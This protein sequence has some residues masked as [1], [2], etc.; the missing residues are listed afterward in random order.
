MK[1]TLENQYDVSKKVVL[2]K[3]LYNC[4]LMYD[5]LSATGKKMPEWVIAGLSEIN[6]KTVNIL[7]DY[8]SGKGKARQPETIDFEVQVKIAEAIA[9]DKDKLT[10]LFNKLT[11]LSA[12]ASPCSLE[13]TIPTHK[14]FFRA[15]PRFVRLI[16]DFWLISLSCLLGYLLLSVF[17]TKRVDPGN[18]LDSLILFQLQLTFSAGLGACFY[19]L[20]TARKYIV[21][22]TFD[23]NYITHYYNR[24]IIGIIAGII[25]ANIINESFFKGNETGIIKQLTP[26][27][28]AL[29]GGYSAEAVVKIL[30]RLVDMLTTLVE[31]D[32]RNMVE[33]RE[34]EIKN[35]FEA[36][37]IKLNIATIID[38]HNLLQTSKLDD[39]TKEKVQDIIDNLLKAD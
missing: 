23:N 17:M 3:L 37:K 27:V 13:N 1:N 20:N 4:E 7:K 14:L 35:K 5:Y 18:G 26:S 32:A 2:Y 8:E 11:D 34:M 9:G 39:K 6:I 33:T 10:L 24:I 28:I 21:A 25:L 29:L 12:P 36:E 22:R 31:G 16:R 19:A 30:N 15:G 38:L